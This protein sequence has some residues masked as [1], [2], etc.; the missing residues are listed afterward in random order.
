VASLA[1]RGDEAV[2][3]QPDDLDQNNVLHVRRVIYDRQMELLERKSSFYW[4]PWFTPI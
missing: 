2:G 3:L 4:M 1:L